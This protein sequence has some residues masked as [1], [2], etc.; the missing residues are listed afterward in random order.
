MVYF[1]DD[2][3]DHLDL[4]AIEQV[5]EREERGYPPYNPRMMAKVLFYAQCVGVRSSRKIARRLEEDVAFRVLAAGNMPKFR[6]IAEFRTRH[7]KALSQ[8][9]AQVL[10]ICDRSGLVP[11]KHVALD[12]AKIRA[13]ASKHKAMSYG[14]MKETRARLESEVSKYLQ[15]TEAVDEQEDSK[16]GPDRRGDE[17][18]EELAIRE[19]RLAKIREAMAALEE[20]ARRESESQASSDQPEDSPESKGGQDSRRGGRPPKDPPGVPN[21]KKQRN[22]TDPESRTM[23]NSD[24]AFIQGYNAQAV[25]DSKCQIIVAAD[26]TNQALDSM[27]LP[28]MVD[29]AARNLGRNPVRLLADAGYCS[30]NNLRYLAEKGIDSYIPTEKQKHGTPIEPA[31]RGSIPR[32]LSLKDRMRRK[33][34]TKRGRRECALR[35]LIVGPVFGQIKEV[36]GLRQ[37]LLRG[38]ERV[39]SEWL[40]DRTR[41]D[42]HPEWLVR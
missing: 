22:F 8:L 41:F 5:Y 11:L 31:P 18:P 9:F 16:F 1:I 42:G 14:R 4:S 38:V 27:R 13:N 3:F 20:E 25:V 30:D 19:K 37:F 40:I 12:G 15:Q 28:K 23:T 2:V 26:L 21:D 35:K 7:I 17:L 32:T 24:K 6:A 10:C 36:R 34:K 33:L 39:R 29:L